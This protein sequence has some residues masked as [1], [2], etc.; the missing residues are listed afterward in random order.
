M[1]SDVFRARLTRLVKDDLFERLLAFL[2]SE[3]GEERREAIVILLTPLFERMV[4]TLC[5]LQADAGKKLRHILELLLRFLHRTVPRDRGIRRYTPGSGDQFPN[6]LGVR[7]PLPQLLAKPGVKTDGAT[8]RGSLLA[9][10][11]QK[12]T[13][14]VGEIIGVV[15]TGEKTID[16][17]IALVRIRV[18]KKNFR[19]FHGGKTSG[20]IE[21]DAPKISPVIAQG[22]RRKTEDLQFFKD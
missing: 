1:R 17:R 3:R 8:R 16:R 9:F 6:P 5:A 2:P 22:R 11:A 10:V 15:V 21:R 20:E 7:R 14:C 4:V 18:P 19:F 13:P 12:R